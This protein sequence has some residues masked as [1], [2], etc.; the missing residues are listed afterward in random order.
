[1]TIT[2]GEKV[3]KTKT[4]LACLA[5]FF[6]G[7]STAGVAEAHSGNGHVSEEDAI[8]T[9]HEDCLCEE[10]GDEEE[11]DGFYACLATAPYWAWGSTC[12][13]SCRDFSEA[14]CDHASY[15]DEEGNKK[16][17]CEWDYH[18]HSCEKVDVDDD[19]SA[20]EQLEEVHAQCR[21]EEGEDS[22][23]CDG[24]YACLGWVGDW[25][26]GYTCLDSCRDFSVYECNDASY[27]DA[28]GDKKYE[29]EWN[30]HHH[31]CEKVD[32]HDDGWCD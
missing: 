7:V 32:L 23:E 30:Y 8:A 1:M 3:S 6:W 5:C 2:M 12:V 11:C 22:D 16:Y 27:Y 29:C 13:D 21:C 18:H 26:W 4:V 19:P 9:V 28:H 20:E 24:A 17:E 15:Y 10:E 14:H 31:S 25:E